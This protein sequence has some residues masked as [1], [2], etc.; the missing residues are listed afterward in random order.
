MDTEGTRNLTV[1][2]AGAKGGAATFAKYGREHFRAIGKKGQAGLEAKITT[3][4][5]RIWGSMGGRP[6]RRRSFD[7]G[8][9][10]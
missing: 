1:A 2:E 10:R 8:E 5:R 9:K 7:T 4:E 6:K 3:L